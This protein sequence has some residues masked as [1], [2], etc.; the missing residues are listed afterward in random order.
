VREGPKLHQP[1]NAIRTMG[2]EH[3]SAPEAPPNDAGNCWS[4]SQDIESHGF[5]PAPKMGRHAGV[6][7]SCS[8][9]VHRA[10]LDALLIALNTAIVV[11]LVI[12]TKHHGKSLERAWQAQYHEV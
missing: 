4:A 1:S 9:S 8:G 5:T 12:D 10:Y 3:P 6:G 11:L 7:R 2:L